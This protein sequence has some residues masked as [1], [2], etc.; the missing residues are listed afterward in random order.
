MEGEHVGPDHAGDVPDELLMQAIPDGPSQNHRALFDLARRVRGLEVAA[1]VKYGM[2]ALRAAIKTWCDFNP[3]LRG[4]QAEA[5]YLEEFMEAFEDVKIPYGSPGTL[6]LAWAAALVAAP[7]PEAEEYGEEC[8]LLAAWCREL[9]RSAGARR[10]FYLGARTVQDRFKLSAP[11][12]A[13]RRLK[14]LCRLGIIEQVEPGGRR[15]AA[16]FRYVR[17]MEP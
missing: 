11:L 8:G 13:W 3:H 7:P 17:P 9:Q 14:L 1:G 12:L 5:D 4:G 10:A 15:L 16:S 6:D 2:A